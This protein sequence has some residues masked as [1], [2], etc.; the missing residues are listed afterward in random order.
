MYINN[1]AIFDRQ[2][3]IDAVV[4]LMVSFDFLRIL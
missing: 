3:S 4:Q 1:T 2:H